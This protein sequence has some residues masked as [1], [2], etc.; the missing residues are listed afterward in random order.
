MIERHPSTG[1]ALP[2][3]SRPEMRP[4][5]PDETRR[6][7]AAAQGD[8]LEAL[9]TLAITTRMRQGEPLGLR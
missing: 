1:A 4:L 8:P 5:T 6:L 9:F 2:R 7:L 3:R